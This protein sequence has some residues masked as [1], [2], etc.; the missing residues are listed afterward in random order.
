MAI[1][2]MMSEGPIGWCRERLTYMNV[3]GQ[4]PSMRGTPRVPF[5]TT[6]PQF[7]DSQSTTPAQPL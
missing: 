1:V 2:M 4:D 3:R 6:R 5:H 7:F